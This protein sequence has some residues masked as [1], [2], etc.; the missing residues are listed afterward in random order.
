[1]TSATLWYSR[2]SSCSNLL[3]TS[4]PAFS[5]WAC[6]TRS[7][8]WAGK[9]TPFRFLVMLIIGELPPRP[10]VLEVAII[11][12]PLQDSADLCRPQLKYIP[13]GELYKLPAD[14]LFQTAPGN[15]RL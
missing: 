8:F 6:E 5:C 11:T 7:C 13:G 12:P 4:C 10:L 2:S 3:T 1:M 14:D 9:C 15:S